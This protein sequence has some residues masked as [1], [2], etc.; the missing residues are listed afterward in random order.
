MSLSS[1]LRKSH[2]AQG[3]IRH[4]SAAQV[5]IG[6]GKL[7]SLPE[8]GNEVR[9][10]CCRLGGGGFVGSKGLPKAFD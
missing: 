3:A 4:Q 5:Q 6:K 9:R 10:G 2:I 1:L 8:G 7:I